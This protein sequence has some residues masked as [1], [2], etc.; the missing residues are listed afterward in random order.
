MKIKRGVVNDI[1]DVFEEFLSDKGIEMPNPEKEGHQDAAIIFG[2]DYDP[3]EGGIIKIF[4][5]LGI[6][7]SENLQGDGDETIKYIE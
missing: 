1:I 5:N 4:E 6:E 7:T 2:S 3:I